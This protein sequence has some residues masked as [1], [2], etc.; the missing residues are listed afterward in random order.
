MRHVGGA[1]FFAAFLVISTACS[2]QARPLAALDAVRSCGLTPIGRVDSGAASLEEVFRS[3][4]RAFSDLA[5]APGTHILLD[6]STLANRDEEFAETRLPAA[7]KERGVA[8]VRFPGRGGSYSES[9]VHGLFY[10]VVARDAQ[11]TYQFAVVSGQAIGRW[12]V[13]VFSVAAKEA[14]L[15]R[16]LL[17]E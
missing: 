16:S 9:F 1:R 10:R 7:L 15:P 8:V 13:L 5:I 4:Q 11:W 3:P 6:A 12:R 17:L 2:N 14:E